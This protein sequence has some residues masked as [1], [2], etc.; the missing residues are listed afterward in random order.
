LRAI[1]YIYLLKIAYE[2]TY[3]IATIIGPTPFLFWKIARAADEYKETVIKRGFR[4]SRLEGFALYLGGR[5]Q[6][7]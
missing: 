2:T 4:R 1:T 7:Q 6:W 3:A 5:R